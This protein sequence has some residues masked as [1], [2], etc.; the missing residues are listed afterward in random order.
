MSKYVPPHMRE[1]KQEAKQEAGP[2]ADEFP[3]LGNVR[4]STVVWGGKKFS[5]V[6]SELEEK[7]LEEERQ[8]M[9]Q[10]NEEKKTVMI[11]RFHAPLPRFN[12]VGHFVEPEE[13]EAPKAE[14]APS[15]GW[16]LVYKKPRREKT[17]EEKLNRPPTPEESTVWQ[18]DDGELNENCWEER[19]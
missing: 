11:N 9:V 17:L 4:S 1:K 15:D 7:R 19:Y 5:Q 8:K 18:P 12:N 13:D 10:E 16:T 14:E 6:A 2:S 3:S